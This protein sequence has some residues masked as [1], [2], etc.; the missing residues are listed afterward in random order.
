ME[1]KVFD[2][3]NLAKLNN[4]IRF[5]ELPPEFIINMAAI[6]KPEVIIDLGAGTG[7]YSTPFAEIYKLCKIYA[8]DISD[9]MINW[10]QENISPKYDNIIPLKM[11]ENNVP[12]N[13]NIADFLFMINLHH[14]LNSPDKMLNECYRLLKP[15]GKI[16]ISDWKKEKTMYGPPIEFRYHANDIKKQLVVAGFKKIDIYSELLNNFLI[17]AEKH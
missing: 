12:L 11:D 15:Q 3:T 13:N 8:C 5:N 7:F 2:P 17:I 10:I 4:P 9:V 1:D 14:E 6:K 16:A